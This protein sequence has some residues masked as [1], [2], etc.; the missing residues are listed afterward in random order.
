MN[1]EG[2]CVRAYARAL[3]GAAQAS[4]ALDAVTQDMLALDAQW[5]GS[6]ELRRFCSCHLK[7][8]PSQRSRLIGQIWGETF[9]RTVLSF[10]EM[11]AQRDQLRFIPLITTRFQELTDRARGCRNAEAAFACAP[12]DAEV[13]RVRRLITETYGPVFKL[14]V[15]VEPALLAGFTLRI[16]DRLVDA[17]L[18]GRIKRLKND[19]MKP[20]RLAAAANGKK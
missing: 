17:S 12:Q 16:D 15:R 18:A 7:G 3:L 10:L 2:A 6:P 19:L 9:S 8:A 1:G 4:Q 14:A 11:L 5:R 13:E 20:E